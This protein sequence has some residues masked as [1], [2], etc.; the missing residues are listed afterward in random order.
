MFKT[1]QSLVYDH[2]G[3]TTEKLRSL[4]I[5]EYNMW[6]TKRLSFQTNI[7]TEFDT[8]IK[9]TLKYT[10]PDCGANFLTSLAIIGGY[11]EMFMPVQSLDDELV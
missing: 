5:E 6:D 1:V 11:R 8:S 4:Q 3:L 10:C 2:H 7:V 9:E